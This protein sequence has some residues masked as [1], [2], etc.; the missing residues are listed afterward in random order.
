MK[1]LR[2][3]CAPILTVLLAIALTGL[4]G[5]A[6]TPQASAEHDADAKAFLSHPAT[7]ALYI[8]RIDTGGEDSVLW[9]DQRIIGATLPRSYFV[10]HLEPGRHVLT[11]Y[12]NDNG[13]L[14]IETRP[15]EVRFVEL[16]VV[17]GQSHFRAVSEAVGRKEVANC[18]YLL[19]N[20]LPGQRPLLR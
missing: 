3:T 8:Y 13:R 6:S 18:C 12:V 10:V 16:R 11:G 5:C 1:P 7:A 2:V 4:S 15:G 17:T 20:W 14:N 19:E 9:I